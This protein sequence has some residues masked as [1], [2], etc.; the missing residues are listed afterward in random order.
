MLA[1]RGVWHGI[2]SILMMS[3]YLIFL[4][5]IFVPLGYGFNL[6]FLH[7]LRT[8]KEDTVERMFDGYKCY[9]RALGLVILQNVLVFLWT[10]LLIVP[11]IIKSF[12]YS[13]AIYVSK[14]HPELTAHKCIKRSE[15][16]MY[17]HKMDLFLLYLSFIGWGLLC[18]LSLGIGFLWLV[19][20]VQVST[21]E[22]Y[23][24]LKDDYEAGD[25]SIAEP[26]GVE[27]Q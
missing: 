18:L 21:A 26:D 13:M 12:A 4:V 15:E 1:G 10:L 23:R 14:D 6:A 17:G 5:L 3:G 25:N 2:A 8:D 20:Y 27:M 7:F 11:G 24:Q 16:M 9:G 19:P 22:F